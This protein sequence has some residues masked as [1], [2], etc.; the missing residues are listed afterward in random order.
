[1]FTQDTISTRRLL[2]AHVRTIVNTIRSSD[3]LL[4]MSYQGRISRHI[5][6]H[7][8]DK[9]LSGRHDSRTD[10]ALRLQN[11]SAVFNSQ[12][13]LR[14]PVLSFEQTKIVAPDAILSPLPWGLI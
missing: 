5:A 12:I 2:E 3:H 11:V 13:V 1:M 6:A 4:K 14:S 10:I 9:T 8:F 7:R